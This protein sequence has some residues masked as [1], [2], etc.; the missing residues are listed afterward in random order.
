MYIHVYTLNTYSSIM[1][2]INES[3]NFFK[4]LG[5]SSDIWSVQNGPGLRLVDVFLLAAR[6]IRRRYVWIPTRRLHT[7][8]FEDFGGTF[9]ENSLPTP[10]HLAGFMWVGRR[11]W[12]QLMFIYFAIPGR[13]HCHSIGTSGCNTSGWNTIPPFIAFTPPSNH[14]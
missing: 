14:G 6:Q 7:H 4:D 10:A 3:M 2:R 1:N 12:C 5:K 9:M 13:R 8:V 11:H